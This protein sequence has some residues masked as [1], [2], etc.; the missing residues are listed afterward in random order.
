MPRKPKKQKDEQPS[1]S[2]KSSASGVKLF[3]LLA[4]VGAAAYFFGGHQEEVKQA[5]RQ[6]APVVGDWTRKGLE[7]SGQFLRTAAAKTVE[8]SREGAE[9]SKDLFIKA[10]QR[11][12]AGPDG[13]DIAVQEQIVTSP[14]ASGE[15]KLSSFNI[16]IFSDKSRDDNELRWI[17][18]ILKHYDI[19][20]IQEVRDEQVLQ[21]TVSILK[22]MGHTF[23][24]EISPP[25]GRTI[26]ERYA[27]F[28]RPDKVKVKHKGEVY[29]DA[30][31]VFIREPYYATFQAGNFDFT[32]L[33]VHILFGDNETDRRPELI[34]L[35]RVYREI[36]AQ[37][38]SEKDVILL[39]DFNFAPDDAGWEDMKDVPAMVFLLDNP[40]RTTI[41]DTSLYDNIWFQKDYVREYSGRAGII[42]FDENMFE[43]DDTRAKK[44]VSDH[45]PIWATFNTA[46]TDDD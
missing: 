32:L 20:A 44:I 29:N 19:I 18:N 25:V 34:E 5:V 13:Q 38:P 6:K 33:T 3:L 16:R 26:K 46:L 31:D 17:A 15:L 2:S 7:D 43:N 36:Q 22:V 21:R 12:F 35:A 14:A 41:S 1:R 37:D 30:A 27:F 42:K 4:A 11:F 10:R 24:Y 40:L 45:R 28:Y 9:K 39:G 23:A 8:L